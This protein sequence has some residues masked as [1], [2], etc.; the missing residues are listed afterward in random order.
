MDGGEL[1]EWERR[2]YRQNIGVDD[3]QQQCLAG[4]HFADHV[5]IGKIGRDAGI[6]QTPDIGKSIGNALINRQFDAGLQI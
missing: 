5:G 2:R 1:I 4:F 3:F 6:C